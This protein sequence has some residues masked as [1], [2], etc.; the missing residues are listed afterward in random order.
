MFDS[1]SRARFY[2]LGALV[3]VAAAALSACAHSQKAPAPDSASPRTQGTQGNWRGG[4]G[5]HMRHRGG[6]HG[7]PML[8]DLNLTKDQQTQVQLI[9]DRY[10]LKA[11]SLRLGGAA[12]DS[13]SREAFRSIMTQEM[14][15]IRAV[16]NPDQ[17]KQFDDQM[18][19]MKERR[20]QH[21][22]KDGHDGPP[23]AGQSGNPPP[24]PPAP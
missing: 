11:D 1:N 24:P 16:L 21:G 18:A 8:K 14:R 22:N 15:D 12:H 19:K 2:T 4:D 6:P 17:Q 5:Q 13:T 7:D 23:P 20:A 10:R 9:R 3:C